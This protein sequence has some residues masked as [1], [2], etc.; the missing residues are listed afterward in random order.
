MFGGN[1]STGIANQRSLLSL[2]EQPCQ[3]GVPPLVPAGDEQ[4]GQQQVD[5]L[6][7]PLSQELFRGQDEDTGPNLEGESG[8][9]DDKMILL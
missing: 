9:Q 5:D 8:T 3:V 6:T 7:D 1:K 2:T 4:L